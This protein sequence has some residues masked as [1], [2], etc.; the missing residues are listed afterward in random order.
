MC[1]SCLADVLYLSTAQGPNQQAVQPTLSLDLSISVKM[2]STD[3]AVGQ[4]DLD[5]VS[6]CP[7]A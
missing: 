4:C 2:L 6:L 7:I 3:R 1:T 5:N